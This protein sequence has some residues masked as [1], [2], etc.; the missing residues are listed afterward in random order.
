MIVDYNYWVDKRNDDGSMTDPTSLFA[1]GDAYERLMGR[2]SG[3]AGEPF[4]DWLN[5]PAGLRWLDVGCGT[6][7]FT[8]RVLDRC[9]PAQIS[10][11][12]PAEGQ[13]AYAR[14]PRGT[15]RGFPHR[16]CP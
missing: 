11:I 7:A 16:R 4:I 14:A 13:I 6:G 12:D 9:A 10:G 15:A 2:W 5:L 1:D 8:E 3:A